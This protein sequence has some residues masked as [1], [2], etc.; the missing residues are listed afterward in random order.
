MV[1]GSRGYSDYGEF[2]MVMNHILSSHLDEKIVI[3]SGSCSSGADKLAEMYAKELGYEVK[4]FPADWNA[5]GKRAGF[6][7]NEGMHKYIAG[8]NSN[9][10]VIAFW[11]GESK[12]TAQSF[13]LAK[14]YG[15][16]MKCYLY[17]EKR[18]L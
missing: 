12:G 16:Q 7:R 3:V 2:K 10:G 9:R 13:E 1:C 14:K 11:D 8:S 15:N 5:Y 18:F 4:L 6:V 17:K